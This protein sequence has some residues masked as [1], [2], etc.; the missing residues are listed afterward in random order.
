MRTLILAMMIVVNPLT[1][2]AQELKEKDV[3]AN[4]K[5]VLAK[6]FPNAKG[7]EWEKENNYFEAGFKINGKEQSVVFDANGKV[8]E[9]E[10]EIVEADLPAPAR[11]YIS[12]KYKG[13]R[14]SEAAKITG[15]DGVV[16]YEAEVNKK[17]LIFDSTGKILKTEE[18][19]KESADK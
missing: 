3:P 4:V 12:S 6:N 13:M 15:A 1:C 16:T 8:L 18:E 9:T 17:D 7:I 2:G 10:V 5:E 11:D 19:G 14:I